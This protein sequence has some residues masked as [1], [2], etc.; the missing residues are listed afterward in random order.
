MTMLS[1]RVASALSF[2]HFGRPK[3]AKADDKDKVYP[4]A[5]NDEDQDDQEER[6]RDDGD[7]KR[8][9]KG[10]RAE[11]DDDTQGAPEGKRAADDS[12]DDEDDEPDEPKGKKGKRAEDEDDSD[13][14]E[15]KQAARS[16]RRSERARCA[17][18]FADRAAAANPQLACHLAFQTGMSSE[19]AIA[20]L[21]AVPASSSVSPARASRN[22]SLGAGGE[23]SGSSHAAIESSWDRA[24]KRATGAR[25]K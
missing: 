20:A 16:A 21:R 3:A 8:S 6:N 4:D 18:I 11:D 5:E 23:V 7:A 12:E 9:K 19:D 17:A 24:M 13:D 14:E 10:K 25:R 2:A 22:P 15:M 1:K